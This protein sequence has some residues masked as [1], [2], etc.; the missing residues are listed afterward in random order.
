M[1][2]QETYFREARS[3]ADD[4][5]LR[6]ARSRKVAWTVAG[7][8]IG[9]AAFEAVALAM[10]VPLKTVQPITLLVDRQTGFVQA[11]DPTT[12]Q[13][14][15]ADA[16]LTNAYLAQYV[17]AREGFDRAT[18]QLDYRRVALWSAGRAR[19]SYLSTMSA[20]N[21]TNPVRSYSAGTIISVRVKSVSRLQ[22]G[23]S[24][25]RFDTQR[26]DRNGQAEAARP[27]IS[28]VRYRY[29]D[30]PMAFGDRLVNPLGF[31]VLGYRRDAEAPVD[32]VSDTAPSTTR[33]ILGPTTPQA[34]VLAPPRLPRRRLSSTAFE[35]APASRA[36]FASI[37]G[38]AQREVPMN[39]IPMGS[40]L[41]PGI[42]IAKLTQVAQP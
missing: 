5:R 41:G 42:G 29:S 1:N 39:Q 8:A 17:A 3:W 36:M 37:G 7:V 23:M 19:T 34:A 25:I 13:R 11:L 12:P 2:G 6:S 40:P 24:L 31:Q 15:A 38:G 18:I 4:N 21:P 35:P 27:W 30:A 22:A 14:V 26:T 20:D 9:A 33:A 32:P 10:L 16:A 28:V